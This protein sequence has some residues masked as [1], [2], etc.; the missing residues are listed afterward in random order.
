MEPPSDAFVY[1]SVFSA[2]AA[3]TT[4]TTTAPQHQ[5]EKTVEAAVAMATGSVVK[6]SGGVCRVTSATL[7]NRDTD[8]ERRVGGGWWVGCW[9]KLVPAY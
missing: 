2:I 7:G 9:A 4:T 3:A 5:P 1:S 8:T 6:C